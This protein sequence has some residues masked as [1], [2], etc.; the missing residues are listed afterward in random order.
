M[1]SSRTAAA[2]RALAR[3]GGALALIALVAGCG[4]RPIYATPALAVDDAVATP[5]VREKVAAT[6]VAPIADRAGQLIRN[7]LAFLI[8]GTGESVAPQYSLGVALTETITT[9]AVQRTGL[10]T[11]ATLRLSAAYTLTELASGAVIWRG[12]A[13][14]AGSFDLLSDEYATLIAERYT[15]EQAAERLARILY[16]RLSAFHGSGAV[17]EGGTG[18]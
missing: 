3:A 14:A 18:G 11:R 6:E 10:A 2:L 9:M 8:A 7:E 1:S 17:A 15:R 12:R 4:F 5:A 13:D 16:L